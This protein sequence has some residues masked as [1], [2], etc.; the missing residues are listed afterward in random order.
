VGGRGREV[1]AYHSLVRLLAYQ[2]LNLSNKK[3]QIR[4]QEQ[5]IIFKLS[6]RSF[7]DEN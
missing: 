6:V 4:T 5:L 7:L 1:P 3:R 2:T